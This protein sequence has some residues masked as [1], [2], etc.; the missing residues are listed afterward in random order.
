MV[1]EEEV[2]ILVSSRLFFVYR[3]VSW[4]SE[5]GFYKHTEN[6]RI[7]VIFFKEVEPG[8]FEVLPASYCQVKEELFH[9]YCYYSTDKSIFLSA[10]YY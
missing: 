9:P 7:K 6:T 8:S 2:S 1:G 10:Q 3:L 4:P 5:A